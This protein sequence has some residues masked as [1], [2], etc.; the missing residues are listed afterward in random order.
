MEAILVSII[1]PVYNVE[2]YL[3]QCIESV[4]GQTYRNLEIWLIDDGS[5]DSS[6]NIC[7]EYAMLDSR[8][9]VIHKENGGLSS[10]RN[11][12]LDQMTGEYVCFLDSDD[13]VSSDLV[14]TYVGMIEWYDADVVMGTIYEF[15]GNINV[16]ATYKNSRNKVEIFSKIDALKMMLMDDK[17][18]HAAAGSLFKSELYKD[19]RFPIGILYEDYATTYYVIEKCRKILYCNDK[20]YFYR[21]RPG[22]I[23]N[24]KVTNRDMVLLDIAD[25]ISDDMI[26]LYPEL[27]IQAIRKKVVVNLKLYSRILNAGFCNFKE[28]KERIKKTIEKNKEQFLNADCV[29][30]IDKIK[31]KI[32]IKGEILF[33]LFYK[34]NDFY[35]KTKKILA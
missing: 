17:L 4:I 35:Q 10:A 11:A 20:R 3:R 2:D 8:I 14:E 32:F 29:R 6:G 9:K 1:I 12:A 28:E 18:Y 15:Y 34:I 19:I 27:E 26:Q 5:K 23:M 16:K 31:L 13:F 7:D 33:Y 24:S 30:K 21:T 22:S 25:K